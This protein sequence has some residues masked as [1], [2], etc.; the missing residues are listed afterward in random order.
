[1]WF[2]TAFQ[3]NNRANITEWSCGGE[4]NST[5]ILIALINDDWQF[6]DAHTTRNM[7]QIKQFII[8][9]NP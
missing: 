6:I 4:L 8:P 5:H 3:F 1:M 7:L 2:N 9:Q